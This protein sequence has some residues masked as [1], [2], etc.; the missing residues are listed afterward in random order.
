MLRLA[1]RVAR[2]PWL[3]AVG[4]R[5]VFLD[6]ALQRWTGGRIAVARIA[7]LT[8][9]LLTTTGRR[10]GLPRDTPLIAIP[11]G[12]SLLLVGSNWGKPGHPA[13]T[14]NLIA[15]PEATIRTRG[16]SFAVTAT[17]LTGPARAQAWSSLTA[18]WPV[19]DDYTARSNRELR[20]FRITRR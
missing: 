17:L 16:H 2:I 15:H 12:G 3:S 19:Y 9:V 11:E 6:T 5:F 14:A 1:Q 10:T 7:G 4:P 20:V 18:T 13:W 8:T